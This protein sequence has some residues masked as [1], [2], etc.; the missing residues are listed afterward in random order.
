MEEKISLDSFLKLSKQ[1][2]KKIVLRIFFFK[3]GYLFAMI[4]YLGFIFI[5][6]GIVKKNILITIVGIILF[7]GPIIFFIYYFFNKLD[8]KSALSYLLIF[9][10]D[11]I[12]NEKDIKVNKLTNYLKYLNIFFEKQEAFYNRDNRINQRFGNLAQRIYFALNNNLL[13]K[14]DHNKIRT[15]AWNLYNEDFGFYDEFDKIYETVDTELPFKNFLKKA[16]EK[17]LAKFI[18]VE[19]LIVTIIILFHFIL[20]SYVEKQNVFWAIILLTTANITIS[21]KK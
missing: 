20:P 16:F 4:W 12:E 21:F 18:I 11:S 19:I 17:N 3:F 5:F 8:K 14:Y 9:I 10:A 1:N 13:N 6:Q 7:I 15:L 2:Y